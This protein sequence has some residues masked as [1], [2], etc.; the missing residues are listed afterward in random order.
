MNVVTNGS[1]NKEA[2]SGENGHSKV[3]DI[4]AVD[5]SVTLVPDHRCHA[6]SDGESQCSTFSSTS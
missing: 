5:G 3:T 4:A 6:M 2:D 1:S